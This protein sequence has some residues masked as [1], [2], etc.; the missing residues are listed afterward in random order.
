MGFRFRKS[1]KI[2]PGVKVNL[3]KTGV[4]GSLGES[5]ASVN[6]RKGKVTSTRG[7]PGSGV[8]YREETKAGKT[9]EVL[10]SALVTALWGIVLKVIKD[11]L[12]PPRRR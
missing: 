5:G 8:S 11:A 9:A 2:A 6:L 7:A 3:T 1:F 4:S 12:K 10:S